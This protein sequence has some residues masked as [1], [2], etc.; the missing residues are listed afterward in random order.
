MFAQLH[1]KTM[2]NQVLCTEAE[3][4]RPE[5]DTSSAYEINLFLPTIQLIKCSDLCFLTQMCQ[6]VWE[7]FIQCGH[8]IKYCDFL[9]AFG[10]LSGNLSSCQVIDGFRTPGSLFCVLG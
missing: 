1:G 6:M 10:T 5:Q 8:T 2:V 4:T 9:S 7:D 3:T